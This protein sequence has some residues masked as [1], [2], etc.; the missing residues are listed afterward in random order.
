MLTQFGSL[1]EQRGDGEFSQRCEMEAR[2]L[3][4]ALEANAWDGEWW[5]RGWFDDGS[6]LGSAANAECRIDSI[7]QSWSVLSGAAN[8]ARA[9]LAM[10]AVDA[11]LIDHDAALVK[12][13]APPFDH[14]TPS[15]GYIQGYLQGVRENGGQYTHAGVWAA[16]AFAALDDG[17]RAWK[18][19]GMLNPVWHAD[20]HRSIQTYR[21]E[22]YVIA[23]DVY[24][25]PPHTGRGG[26][27][28]YTGAAG[29][30]LRFITES[31]LGLKVEAGSLQITPCFAEGW[32]SY[33][34]NYRYRET[35]YRIEVKKVE[36][37]DESPSLILD[38][39]RIAGMVLPLVDD[40]QPHVAEFQIPGAQEC[41]SE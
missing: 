6:P 20:S 27:T 41:K 16:M 12:L 10:D 1:A 32:A 8:P 2:R 34:L 7:A 39:T 24:A 38:G 25:L 5:R 18:L 17:D 35:P 9:R 11:R 13:L 15:P 26:W 37:G 19:F 28:W 3:R 14:S 30:M 22:P 31:L 4:G 29:W 21:T 36:K 33:T 23:S 40:G